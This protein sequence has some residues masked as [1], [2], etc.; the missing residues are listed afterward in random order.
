[1]ENMHS[2]YQY[3]SEK[4]DTVIV[5]IH[6]IQ[7]SPLQFNY[8]IEGLNGSYSIENLLLPG[9]GK[10]VYDFSQSNIVQWQNY[11]DKKI[12]QLQNKYQNIILVGH[13]MGCLL[14]VNTTILHPQRIRGLFLISIPLKIHFTFTYIKNNL[15]VA[16]CKKDKNEITAAARKGNS[17]LASSPFEYIKS[18]PRYIELI[19]KSSSTKKQIEKLELPIIV[20]HSENDEIVS[21]KTL[22]YFENRQN[23]EFLVVKNSGHYYYSKEAREQILDTLMR[24]IADVKNI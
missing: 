2:E 21:R 9:H 8:L 13:S 6:G 16:F 1:M 15:H 20:V 10:T 19:N 5:F 12:G 24:F 23:A 18:I 4:S 7:G 17:I 22:L 11:V 3:T 14:S